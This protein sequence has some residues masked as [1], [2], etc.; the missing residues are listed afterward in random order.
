VVNDSKYRNLRA[1]TARSVYLSRGEFWDSQAPLYVRTIGDPARLIAA[2]RREAQTLNR[3]AYVYD[4]RTLEDQVDE[5][6]VQERL[7]AWLASFFG[8]LAMLLS[9]IGLY[10]VIAYSVLRRTREIGLRVALGAGRRHIL[11]M[12]LREVLTLAG[13]GVALGVPA[14]LA[15][16]RLAKTL[17]FGVAPVDTPSLLGAVLL[18]C[19]VAMLAGYLPARRATRVD[20]MVALRQ[21]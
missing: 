10:G 8:L 14:A 18:M 21:E 2:V 15:A 1:N 17:L 9:A 5:M 16:A 4:V 11:R 3:D 13:I 7:V 20:P 12:V 6:L 19:A